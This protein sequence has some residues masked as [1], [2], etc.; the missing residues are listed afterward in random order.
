MYRNR[1]DFKY[2]V[3]VFIST[4][5]KFNFRFSDFWG[6][7]KRTCISAVAVKE[8]FEDYVQSDSNVSWNSF[9]EKSLRFSY[10]HGY[11]RSCFV[12]HSTAKSSPNFFTTCFPDVDTGPPTDKSK[13]FEQNNKKLSA[14]DPNVGMCVHKSGLFGFSQPVLVDLGKINPD[15]KSIVYEANLEEYSG[16]GHVNVIKGSKN[17]AF[18]ILKPRKTIQNYQL[19][20]YALKIVYILEPGTPLVSFAQSTERVQNSVQTDEAVNLH[21]P[22]LKELVDAILHKEL[23][24]DEQECTET[25]P[26]PSLGEQNGG[27]N[28][29]IQQVQVQPVQ[30]ESTQTPAE[31]EAVQF[32]LQ[33]SETENDHSQPQL[34]IIQTLQQVQTDAVDNTVQAS[35]GTETVEDPTQ[36]EIVKDQVQA[37]HTETVQSPAVHPELTDTDNS[38]EQPSLMQTRNSIEKESTDSEQSSILQI[39]TNTVQDLAQS[40]VQQ[41]ETFTVQ[42]ELTEPAQSTVKLMETNNIQKTVQNENAHN[43]SQREQMKTEESEEI[44]P[45]YITT[46]RHR[47][48]TEVR[49]KPP[50]SVMVDIQLSP[51]QAITNFS[52]QDVFVFEKKSAAC[53]N[54]YMTIIRPGSRACARIVYGGGRGAGGGGGGD[55]FI[56]LSTDNS[57]GFVHPVGDH[58][59]EDDLDLKS[60]EIGLSKLPNVKVNA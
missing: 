54:R 29:L 57:C 17:F 53:L 25:V 15:T 56:Y 49:F 10:H 1:L 50:A 36:T 31:P 43:P 28:N 47:D 13:L 55:D 2:A 33:T 22:E 38:P 40:P 14:Q 35:A 44:R 6:T 21:I 48:Q 18:V 39:D 32:P 23:G 27:L 4:F 12:N 42:E 30:P 5:I 16:K 26:N 9:N 51:G 34:E 8:L 59:D 46:L 41:M 20:S 3:E 19:H 24:P 52:T 60:Q 7:E 37:L 11:F 58:L 45:L